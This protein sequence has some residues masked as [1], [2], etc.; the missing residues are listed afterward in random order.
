MNFQLLRSAFILLAA[1]ALT[2]ASQ[3]YSLTGVVRDFKMYGTDGGHPDFE[4][5]L[6]TQKGLVKDQLGADG[7]P[8]YSGI[9]NS[10]VTSES[11]FNQWF[12]NSTYST[13]SYYTIDMQNI[14]NGVYSYSNSNFFPVDG[15][16]Y[17]NQGKSHNYAFTYQVNS[18]FGYE[19]AKN[20]SLTFTG[21]DDV[22]IYIN[23]KLAIDLGGVHGAQSQTVKLNDI[24]ASF[25]LV[26]GSNYTMN[27]FFAE[28]HTTQSNFR[29]DTTLELQTTPIPVPEPAS[30]AV[31]AVGISG[32]VARRRKKA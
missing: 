7:L 27:V 32:I 23:G 15:Q 5:Y 9:Q 11:S 20:H 6:G 29:M 26:D 1:T 24:A 28:R 16:G 30:M 17:G 25:G 8:V 22:F 21:D 10:V 12:R 13:P 2:A 18:T 31:I 4:R 14:G 3:A 19:K